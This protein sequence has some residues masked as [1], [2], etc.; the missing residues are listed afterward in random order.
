MSKA[1][2]PDASIID[3]TNDGMSEAANEESAASGRLQ[4]GTAFDDRTTAHPAEPLIDPGTAS[5]F[6]VPDVTLVAGISELGRTAWPEPLV[7]IIAEDGDAQAA[8]T[9]DAK[10]AA[11]ALG[12]AADGSSAFAMRS[13][14]KATS[15]ESGRDAGCRFEGEFQDCVA[16]ALTGYIRAVA[17]DEVHSRHSASREGMSSAISPAG[18]P[19]LEAIGARLESEAAADVAA[20]AFPLSA[21]LEDDETN[22]IVAGAGDVEP[23]EVLVFSLVVNGC[24]LGP[25][26]IAS[27]DGSFTFSLLPHIEELGLTCDCDLHASLVDASNGRVVLSTGGPGIRWTRFAARLREYVN[28]SLIGFCFDT[29]APDLPTLVS[30][31]VNGNQAGAGLACKPSRILERY[32]PAPAAAGFAIRVGAL[33]PGSV[34]TVAL[35]LD[36]IDLETFL[37]IPG[38]DVVDL[39]M[40]EFAAGPGLAIHGWKV[41]EGGWRDKARVSVVVDGCERYEVEANQIEA[42]AHRAGGSIFGG[43]SIRLSPAMVAAGS[44]E[45]TLVDPATGDVLWTGG[46]RDQ[47]LR[48]GE[49]THLLDFGSDTGEDIA[50]SLLFFCN[51]NHL[52]ASPEH[53]HARQFHSRIALR[54]LNR[55]IDTGNGAYAASVLQSLPLEAHLPE[56]RLNGVRLFFRLA[57]MLSV[58]R[59][60]SLRLAMTGSHNANCRGSAIFTGIELA[61]SVRCRGA[62]AQIAQLMQWIQA[63]MFNAEAHAIVNEIIEAYAASPKEADVLR[64]LVTF[65][66]LATTL[67]RAKA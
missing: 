41:S 5:M 34:V 31:K 36:K 17:R 1:V 21:A 59:A 42:A 11:P 57:R 43:F 19:V 14:A 2:G 26:T 46:F 16:G 47:D 53:C 27:R 10:P 64:R 54:V 65:D 29:L 25:R 60:E 13:P 44:G 67:Q 32:A 35:P 18:D 62:K 52:M 7:T 51:L 38:N 61:L 12:E 37:L 56:W 45:V 58:N 39:P 4:A 63:M 23:H 24:D 9:P 28:G 6:A 15:Q 48:L 49:L 8:Q 20:L 3:A 22:Y 66:M 50:H 55:L 33:P 30:A 40:H